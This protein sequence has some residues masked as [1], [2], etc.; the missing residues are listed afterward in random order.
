[1]PDLSPQIHPKLIGNRIPGLNLG[2]DFTTPEYAGHSILNLSGSICDLF[3]VPLLGAPPLATEIFSAIRADYQNIVLLL[4]DALSYYLFQKWLQEKEFAVWNNLLESGI[5]APLTS[6]VPSTTCAA[7]T[8]IWTAKSPAEHGIAGYELWLKEYG[9]VANMILHS[10]FSFMGQSGSLRSAGF[11]PTAFLNQR[12]LGSHLASYGI[13]TYAMQP[14]DIIGSGLS[15]MFFPDVQQLGYQDFSDLCLRARNLLESTSDQKSLLWM[16]LPD[17][18]TLSHMFGPEDGQVRSS[19][20]EFSRAFEELF[21]S[22]LPLEARRKTLF[23]LVADHGQISTEKDPHYDLRNHPNLTRRLHLQPTGENR[24]VYLYVKPGQMEAV[25]EFIERTWPNQF[26]IFDSF[27]AQE[28]GLFGQGERHP[29]LHERLGDLILAA[30]ASAYLWW[31]DRENPLMG[32]HGGLSPDEM[33]VPL[34]AAP[35]G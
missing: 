22:K 4:V 8:S 31:G 23:L 13:Q 1:M 15:E 20:E 18:D 3:G 19:F 28:S 34:L 27:Y 6:V 35:L 5:L 33:L 2:E 12:T 7:L 11:S 16:Y 14:S 25:R 10:P 29:R 9:L 17:V 30:R 26:L 24:L 32:R 21:L